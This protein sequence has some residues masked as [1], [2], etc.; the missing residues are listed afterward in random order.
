MPLRFLIPLCLLGLPALAQQQSSDKPAAP[1]QTA[2]P[3]G[4][5]QP[6]ERHTRTTWHYHSGPK[7][8]AQP[9]GN[10]ST[11]TAPGKNQTSTDAG[12]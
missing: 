12:K 3:K 10:D 1:Q 6:I 2:V 9:A 5:P 8:A 7:R 4:R 11:R